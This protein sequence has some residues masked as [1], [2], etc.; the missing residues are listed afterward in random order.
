MGKINKL[1]K[2][3]KNIFSM[4]TGWVTGDGLEIKK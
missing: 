3:T 2:N 4:V 1:Q